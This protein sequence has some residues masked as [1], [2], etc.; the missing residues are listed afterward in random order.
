M[1]MA[2][3]AVSP[4]RAATVFGPVQ[5]AMPQLL[6]EH[7]PLGEHRSTVRSMRMDHHAGCESFSVGGYAEPT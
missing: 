6:G 2:A 3:S 1:P 5:C 4:S 7:A